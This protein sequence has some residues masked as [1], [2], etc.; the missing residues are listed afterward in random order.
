MRAVTDRNSRE[1]AYRAFL[2]KEMEELDRAAVKKLM[3][4]REGRWLF[5]RLLK[6]SGYGDLSMTGNSYTFFKE[7]SRYVGVQLNNMVL[8][9]LGKDGLVL[10]QKG[11]REC[12]EFEEHAKRLFQERE[13]K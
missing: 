12:M 5:L 11:E 13:G 10:K 9:L 6:I 3:R 7:G 4:T 2:E 8:S 1:A